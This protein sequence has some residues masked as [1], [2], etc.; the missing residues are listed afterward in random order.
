MS[1][2]VS[3]RVPTFPDLQNAYISM[4]FNEFSKLGKK[5]KVKF[6]L[7]AQLFQDFYFT[8]LHENSRF[9][10]YTLIFP[11]IPGGVGTLMTIP[12]FVGVL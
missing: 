1:I 2:C 11:V 10:R 6:L 9:S 4:F 12:G 8:K 5:Q 3:N 7:P